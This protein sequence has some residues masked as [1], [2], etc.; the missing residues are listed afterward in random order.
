MSN[1]RRLWVDKR[2]RDYGVFSTLDNHV[3]LPAVEMP[4]VLAP[5]KPSELRVPTGVAQRSWRIMARQFDPE[6][7]RA[8][9]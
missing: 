7:R 8:D 5:L 4:S 2:A 9:L 3:M 1:F 6:L